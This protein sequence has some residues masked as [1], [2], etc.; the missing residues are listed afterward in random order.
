MSPVARSN[1]RHTSDTKT[2]KVGCRKIFVNRRL[3]PVMSRSQPDSDYEPEEDEED[4]DETVTTVRRSKRAKTM[5]DYKDR[6]GHAQDMYQ[7]TR[8]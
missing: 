1:L 8:C 5:P 3:N 2:I 4:E 7:W 6:N